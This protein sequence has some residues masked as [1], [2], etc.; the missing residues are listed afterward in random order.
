MRARVERTRSSRAIEDILSDIESSPEDTWSTQVRERF[1]DSPRLAKQAL[2]W[3][4]AGR[5]PSGSPSLGVAGERFELALRIDSG[6]TASVWQA[7]DHKLERNVAIKV[8]HG[9]DSSRIHHGL[10]EARAA[11]EVISEH[12]V[13]VHDVHDAD[14]PYI[15]LELVAE[16]EPGRRLEL[17]G[18]AATVAPRDLAEAV[19]W[20][21]DVA[22]GVHAAHLHGVFHRDLK[23]HN[24]LI[25]PLSRRAKIADFGLAINAPADAA[26]SQPTTSIAGT[27]AYMAPEQARGAV[28]PV[29]ADDPDEHLRAL[30]AIDVWGL[31]AIAYQLISGD[32]P[33][34]R[35]Y[36]SAWELA[37]SGGRPEPLDRTRWGQAV[38][39]R[40]RRIVER[41]LAL[42]PDDRYATAAAVA[43]E[44]DAYLDH[45]PTS[46]DTG[47]LVRLRLWIRRNPHL[48]VMAAVAIALAS[49][50]LAAYSTVVGL[51]TKSRELASDIRAVQKEKRQ[52]GEQVTKVRQDLT[53]TE[54]ALRRQ[55]TSL[56]AVV[57]TL[58]ETRSEYEHDIA[59]KNR[60]LRTAD[61]ATRQLA[62]QVSATQS[63]LDAAERGRELYEGFWIRAREQAERVTAERDEALHERDEA[64]TERDRA[65]HQSETAT[66]ARQVAER[67]R[68][69]MRAERDRLR[70]ARAL[71]LEIAQ[72]AGKLSQVTSNTSKPDGDPATPATPTRVTKPAATADEARPV[73]T[74]TAKTPKAKTA[75]AKAKTARAK[76]ARVK[77]ANAKPASAKAKASKAKPADAAPADE[78]ERKGAENAEDAEGSVGERARS[79]SSH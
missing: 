68:D 21:R 60:E 27:P 79:K 37:A 15:V 41:A 39:A 63:D 17:G 51:R 4:R 12:V 25:T 73:P 56:A 45:H 44:L 48:T 58:A 40:L 14:P 59:A 66:L 26:S 76:T 46:F 72:L 24:V 2:I 9:G 30:A 75:K 36:G 74:P 42:D 1:A 6:A 71:E 7:Y 70:R 11:S 67:E 54:T 19:R 65:V 29:D 62:S 32:P 47:V 8:F 78:L 5:S 49:M 57:R 23:P 52:L 55:S 43:D 10:A 13:R 64:R 31:G 28:G 16:R 3:L 33:W 61:S 35:R 77:S 50:T 53:D 22:R 18:S 69:A 34:H 20:V 38:P